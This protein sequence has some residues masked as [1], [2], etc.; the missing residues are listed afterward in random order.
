MLPSS[1][2]KL[3]QNSVLRGVA[4]KLHLTHFARDIYTRLLADDG[5]LQVS[6]LGATAQFA[7]IRQPQSDDARHTRLSGVRGLTRD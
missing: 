6:C 3:S 4:G 2:R 1:I 7:L 5:V